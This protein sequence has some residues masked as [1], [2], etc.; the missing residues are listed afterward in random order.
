MDPDDLAAAWAAYREDGDRDALDALV[1]QY[2]P[3][4]GY[5]AR[6]ALVK[7]PEHQEAEEILSFAQDGLLDALRKYDPAQGVKFETYATRRIAGEIVDGLRRKDPLGRVLRRQVKQ[8]STA[9]GELGEE[10]NRTPT[11]REIAERTGLEE[12]EVRVALLAQQTVNDTLEN[13]ALAARFAQPAEAETSS[14][15]GELAGVVAHRIALMGPRE[16][17][18]VLAHYVDESNIKTTA[19][20]LSISTGQC[21][22]IRAEVWQ[23]IVGKEWR[24]MAG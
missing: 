1:R 15:E 20:R 22:R 21:R 2:A 19:E 9:A 17:A 16:R 14:Q 4:A 13:P 18:F 6:R 7:A 12:S 24:G 10:T 11:T 8:V 3:L 23:A 5:L